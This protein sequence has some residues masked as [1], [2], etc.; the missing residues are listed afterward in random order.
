[1]A[2]TNLSIPGVDLI[3]INQPSISRLT[4]IQSHGVLLVLSEPTLTI[5]QV[6]NNTT[7]ALGIAP[8]W[9][10][11]QPLEQILDIFQVEQFRAELTQKTLDL[12]NYTKIWIRKHTDEYS[13]FDA[14]FHRSPDGYL[15]LE[16]EPTEKKETIPF[17]SF[18]HLAKAAIDRLTT[19]VNLP[20]FGRIVVT[21]VRKL[22]GF[23]RVMLYKFDPDGHGEVI[24]EDRIDRM[25][26]YLG[27]HFP[28][29]DIPGYARQLFVANRVRAIFD[30]RE[31]GVEILPD[32]N[33]LTKIPTDLTLSILRSAVPCHTEY[34]HNMGVRASLTISLIKNGQLWGIIVCHHQTPKFVSYELRKACELLGQVIF[35]EI[36]TTEDFADAKY[37]AKLAHDQ[38]VAIDRISKSTSLVESLMGNSPNLLD[39]VAAQGAA[40]FAGGN[41]TTIGKTPSTVALDRLMRWLT[42]NVQDEVFATN[43]LSV[44]NPA[45]EPFIDIASGLLAIAISSQTYLL[46]F[47]PEVIQSMNWGGDPDLDFHSVAANGNLNLHPCASFDAWQQSIAAHALPWNTIEIEAA[48]ELRKSI[49]QIALRQAEE[50]TI[51]AT[52]LE[53]SNVELQQF[54]Y[55]ASHDLQEPLNQVASYVQ[56]LETRYSTELDRDAKEFIGFAV[57]GVNLMQTLIDDVLLY[58]KVGFEG[59]HW[60]PIKL[61]TALNRAL[62]HLRNQIDATGTIVTFDPLPTIV[63]DST[64][65]TQL[66]QN[67][68]GNAIK[69]RK[70][71]T[72]P[73]IHI[74]ATQREDDWLFAVCA[75]GIGIESQYL[76][77]IFTIFQ[78][79]HTRDEYPGTGMGLTICKKIVECH[80]GKIWATSEFGEGTTFWFTIPV[81]GDGE[82]GRRGDG[83]TG[84]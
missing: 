62:S 25:E 50:L 70:P 48:I 82:T 28:E 83:E 18:Y 11:G 84:R 24:A 16:L 78:R 52:N 43:A 35:A 5:L 69:F 34:L 19:T 51:I 56:L 27:L 8:S 29:S 37:R 26:S 47:R 39:L 4:K 58:S 74:A 6:S 45:T 63:A 60:E 3:K 61:E 20:A 49:V 31:Q 12:H 68:I 71:D 38:F 72:I 55:V 46:C 77:R 1:M 80:Q 65:I 15:I 2:G 9:M 57:E 10:V 32:Q 73:Q 33:P 59:V 42:E 30:A 41:W 36:A 13:I 53:R 21:E 64:Q 14:V 7:E 44:L 75:D 67:L 76:D 22:T 23:D 66:F 81:R 40:I 17:L 54:A 79:L